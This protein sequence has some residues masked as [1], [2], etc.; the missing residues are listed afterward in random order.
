M[1]IIKINLVKRIIQSTNDV[2]IKIN[3]LKSSDLKH[4]LILKSYPYMINHQ[5]KPNKLG[6]WSLAVRLECLND[7]FHPI[8]LFKILLKEITLIVQK[9][10]EKVQAHQ[11]L[12]NKYYLVE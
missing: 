9:M 2:Q 11:D 8:A 4:K 12:L 5:L 3:K 1:I 6:E 10:G 7:F